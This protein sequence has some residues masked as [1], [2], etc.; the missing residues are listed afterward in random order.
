MYADELI[1]KLALRC[2]P[3]HGIGDKSYTDGDPLRIVRAQR[4]G[5]IEAERTG[6][7]AKY[8]GINK[9]LPPEFNDDQWYEVKSGVAF[10]H[11]E[12][13][14]CEKHVII[15]VGSCR[16]F[17]VT[18]KVAGAIIKLLELLEAI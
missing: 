17:K 13:P 8:V 18:R 6:W 14:D 5:S 9:W 1:G 16:C 2:G 3:T 12:I 10:H 4:C 11:S 15:R 7:S